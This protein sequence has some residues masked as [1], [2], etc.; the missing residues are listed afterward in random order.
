MSLTDLWNFISNSVYGAQAIVALWGLYC[1]VV[2]YARIGQ[3]RFSSE[4][5]QDQFL[6]SLTE[7]MAKGNL[8]G[9]VETCSGDQRA[10][11]QL[12]ELALL[13]RHLSFGKVRQ[14][15]LDRFQRDVLTDI[16]HRMAW[17]NTVVKT[18]PMLGLLGTV[19]GMMAAFGKLSAGTGAKAE[20]LAQDIAFALITTAIG[21]AISIPLIIVMSS[22]NV[23]VRKLEDSVGAGLTRF[24]DVFRAS[25]LAPAG[26]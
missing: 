17:I 4:A 20:D 6:E 5:V 21:L 10:I 14:L 12:A 23:R 2:I 24:F 3:K 25:P 22:I 13:N 26:K 9:A 18:E 16:E 8:Q 1:V 11:C 15:V 19:L 7:E